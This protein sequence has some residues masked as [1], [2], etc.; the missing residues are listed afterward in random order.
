MCARPL[1]ARTRIPL[2]RPTF[3]RA[4]QDAVAAVLESGWVVQG[5]R[6]AEFERSFQAFTGADHAVAMSSCTTALHAAVVAMGLQPGDEVIV[7]A[8]TWVATANVVELTGA[9]PVFCDVRLDT[10]NLDERLVPGLVTE[11]TVGLIPVHLFGLAA[12]M[13]PL[14]EVAR[15]RGLWLVEDAACGLGTR[16]H[17]RHVGLD[18]DVGCFSFHPR[19][20]ITTGEGGMAISRNGDRASLLRSLRDHGSEA[21][22]GEDPPPM[23]GMPS[24]PRPGFNYRMTDIQGAI[25]VAQMDRAGAFIAERQRIA[26]RYDEGL[27]GLDWLRTPTVPTGFEH[28]Y[29]SYVVMIDE[30]R[31]RAYDAETYRLRDRLMAMLDQAGIGSRPGTHAPPLSVFYRERYGYRTEDFPRAA[32]A[33]SLSVALPLFPGLADEDVDYVIE[34]IRS[35]EA[36]FDG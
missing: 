20:S 2:A 28:G 21:P 19:K 10:F 27:R 5:P 17:G 18:G 6:V 26:R 29:Q 3:G 9:R 4:E 22:S 32:A 31:A 15:Q 23:G 33:E 36:S 13:D 24:F 25:G 35:S 34:T 7:P 11:R 16:I 14:V 12:E 1:P 30:D 8:L